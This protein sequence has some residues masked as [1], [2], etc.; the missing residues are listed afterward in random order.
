MQSCRLLSRQQVLKPNSEVH[1]I[2]CDFNLGLGEALLSTALHD[3]GDAAPPGF[4][5]ATAVED[6]GDGGIEGH[7][8]YA[9]V[10]KI[11][12]AHAGRECAG[13]LEHHAVVINSQTGREVIRIP[14][15]MAQHVDGSLFDG[16][17]GH[18]QRILTE[19]AIHTPRKVEMLK[20][21]VDDGIVLLKQVALAH[22]LVAEYKFISALKASESHLA[23]DMVH[24]GIEAEQGV[25]RIQQHA[26]IAGYTQFL[27][28]LKR[29]LQGHVGCRDAASAD[30]IVQGLEYHLSVDILYAE[31][32]V[33]HILPAESAG[34]AQ[35]EALLVHS[36]G[37][38]GCGA[39]HLVECAPVK[40]VRTVL[41]I[42][43]VK[44]DGNHIELRLVRQFD[45]LHFDIN[46]R[47]NLAES[48]CYL[49]SRGIRHVLP[50][51][52]EIRENAKHQPAAIRVQECTCRLHAT[53]KLTCSLFQLQ[54]ARFILCNQLLYFIYGHT[55]TPPFSDMV[56]IVTFG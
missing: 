28:H 41:E 2:G 31:L 33:G 34:I 42:S 43:G 14:R 50:G 25:G 19:L 3:E 12:P 48:V 5:G 23:L 8:A 27:H 13:V 11:S 53:M 17:V 10:H 56:D 39:L 45:V 44:V 49:L 7:G 38:N 21:E 26:I 15:A 18:G 35:L 54:R 37:H 46:S 1:E 51:N 29:G 16:C 9:V 22:S 55:V 40:R 36:A 4:H 6:I 47:L 52:L 24:G 32:G 20:T 30:T